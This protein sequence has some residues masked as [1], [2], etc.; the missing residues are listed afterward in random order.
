[1]G[2]GPDDL[3]T[4]WSSRAL[5]QWQTFFDRVQKPLFQRTGVLWLGKD[6]DSY[7]PETLKTLQRLNIPV[8]QLDRAELEKRFPQFAFDDVIFGVLE[9]DS[10]VL[11]ARQAVQ[12]VVENVIV[13]G[14]TYISGSIVQPIGHSRLE[15]VRT[16]NGTVIHANTFVFACG[17]WL[18]K[19]FPDI[20]ANRLFVTRQEVFF[21][22]TPAGVKTFKPG[23]MPTWICV[24]DQAYGMPDLENR[25]IKFAFDRHG[26]PF[27]P[28]DGC[29]VV[30]T[31]GV[32]A[33]RDY[34]GMRLRGSKGAPIL[35]TRVCQYENTSNGDF[36]IDRHPAFENVWLAGGGSGHGFKHGPVVGEYVSDLA[37]RGGA[38]DARFS[39]ATKECVQH[40]VIL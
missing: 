38:T 25:G 2:Y 27:D 9:P 10:G 24:G 21:F 13:K 22:G 33:A 19:I 20:L 17:P 14:A 30:T 16:S 39:L 11:M 4:R 3:Y 29:R 5:Q 31:E 15:A 1:M 18:G 23:S 40:R 26:P 35:E 7:T 32:Q 37:V 8:E 36:L 34:V 28:D 12:A 6:G